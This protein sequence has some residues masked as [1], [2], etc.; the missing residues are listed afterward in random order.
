[1]GRG[2]SGSRGSG[3]ITRGVWEVR[4]DF[5]GVPLSVY[6]IV[7]D[8][9]IALV[10][11]GVAGSPQRHIL[12][13]LAELGA[14]AKDVS[15]LLV[16]HAHHD[17]VGGAAALREANPAL[18][19]AVHRADVR[20]AESSERYFHELY[21]LL[22]PEAT[23]PGP[24]FRRRVASLR[25]AGVAVDRPLEDEDVVPAAGRQLAVRWVPAHCPGHV[26]FADQEVL[27]VGDA[28]QGRGFAIEGR[29]ALF[30]AYASLAVY[31]RS[32]AAIDGWGARYT[33][34]AHFGVLDDDARRDLVARS[35]DF[36]SDLDAL[37]LTELTRR[38]SLT[39]PEGASLA[40]ERWPEFEPGVQAFMTVDAHLAE[41]A[42][43]G[44]A[45]PRLDA[46][47]GKTWW[48]S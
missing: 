38:G 26:L 42:R 30:P 9:Q 17:H 47:G 46:G 25:G 21:E 32:L 16:T 45:V 19:V 6:L 3:E 33:C 2:G 5:E 40:L 31:R 29:R 20:W 41:L 18:P 4:A 43:Q 34:T 14:G 8:G 13:A 36:T 15:L 11:C 48:A 27:F 7:G 24:A 39:V 12:P 35:L 1:M 28:L 22:H 44:R 23:R 37:L 10:D